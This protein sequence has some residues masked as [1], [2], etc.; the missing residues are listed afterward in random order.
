MISV[1]FV[2]LSF[3]FSS[4]R[5]GKATDD[6][7]T[8]T[9]DCLSNQCLL[10]LSG[11]ITENT[12]K[13]L[14]EEH[15]NGVVEGNIVVLESPGGSLKAAIEMGRYFR[16][17]GLNVRV[18]RFFDVELKKP[19]HN[20]CLS[21]CAYAFLG[22]NDRSI[23]PEAK[24]GIHRFYV[25][26]GGEL[27]VELSKTIDTVQDFT[28]ELITY[29][30]QMGID[31][32]FF[33]NA[34]KANANE[35]EFPTKETLSKWGVLPKRGFSDFHLEPYKNG[36]IAISKNIDKHDPFLRAPLKQLT[37]FCKD[38]VPHLLFTGG[39]GPNEDT[40]ISPFKVWFDSNRVWNESDISL[41][42]RYVEHRNSEGGTLH[43]VFLPLNVARKVLSK[44]QVKLG[45]EYSG[46][47]GGPI[48]FSKKLTAQ[49][50]K[51]LA[52]AFRLCI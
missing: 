34:N 36:V 45:F 10:T 13:K 1:L 27:L 21:A 42:S 3:V 51:M 49:D 20:Q 29:I 7:M 6:E 39:V 26:S 25:S 33:I 16:A 17:Q 5:I 22:G 43:D 31:A 19:Y 38:N 4:S 40:P 46:A 8:F 44:T 9:H 48:I 18:G 35:M 11:V 52:T 12:P 47:R 14:K 24:L 2:A 32:R 15:P 41:P 28:A 30:T 50:K 23:D 37:A